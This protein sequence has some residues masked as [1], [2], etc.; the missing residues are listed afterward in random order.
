MI[1]L[2][3]L[4]CTCV[5]LLRC[6]GA[7][8]LIVGL[9]KY[10]HDASCCIISADSGKVLFSQA[11][12]RYSKLKH[13][14]GAVGQLL[15]AGLRYV[16][17][18]LGDIDTVVSNNH[19]FRV[20][21]FE[22]R[23]PFYKSLKYCP[24][25]YGEEH[26][27]VPGATHLELSH[28][29][30]HAWSVTSSLPFSKGIIVVMDGMGESYKAMIEDLSGAEEA[31]GDYMHD[32]KLLKSLG[33][34]S[35]AAFSGVPVN[36]LP[37]SGYR[38][39]ESAYIYDSSAAGLVPLFKRW[40]RERS[41]PELYNHGFENMESLG[42]VYS[43]VSSHLLGD[44]NACGKVM[45]LAS[46]S[47]VKKA[48]AK[49]WMF[50]NAAGEIGLGDNFYHST[51]FMTGNPFDKGGF[52]INWKALDGLE[53]SNSW[54]N[55]NFGEYACIANSVQSDLEGSALSLL[56]SLQT[57]AGEKNVA[58][59]GGV[60]LNSVLNGR[61]K[62][63]LGG[64]VY[65]PPGPG[66]EGVAV[67]CAL[68]GLHRY[69]QRLA[70][71]GIAAGLAPAVPL[72]TL[73]AAAGSFSAYQ[74][75]EYADEDLREALDEWQPFISVKKHADSAAT[76][77]SAVAKLTN[78]KVVAWF[79]GRSEFGQR[80][81]GSRSILA[82]PRDAQMRRFINEKVKERE[83][84]RP[85]APSALDEFA[86]D[87]FDGLANGANDSP[88]MSITT[89]V[90][91]SRRAA[92]PAI[93][94]IDGSARLQTVRR[95]DN[96]LYHEL[97]SAFYRATGVP[98][99]LNT[100]FNRKKQPI[101]ESPTDAVQTLLQ[102]GGSI[103]SLFLGNYEVRARAFPLSATS[104]EPTEADCDVLV[105]ARDVYMTEI[106][107]S[108][109]DPDT[110]VRVRVQDGSEPGEGS[111]WRELP[112]QLTLEMLLLLQSSGGLGDDEDGSAP[113]NVYIKNIYEA[114][115]QIYNNDDA[116]DG[117]PGPQ[118]TWATMRKSL[119]VLHRANLV[120]FESLD[121]DREIEDIDELQRLFK[122]TKI[123]D[124]RGLENDLEG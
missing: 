11:K 26:N 19:H 35:Q 42:A 15:Q 105:F 55:K 87:W 57:A 104:E 5:C 9:N 34:E 61:V 30:A 3:L 59:T 32:L 122:G 8:K 68:Y 111:G 20:R 97:I 94:H 78:G 51:S 85:L 92:V 107:S 22:G 70:A 33:P 109:Q 62:A 73:S 17:A 112:D 50:E 28:H 81:L 60:A 69:K 36:L 100:S 80:A 16:G 119:Q 110:P 56:R 75:E 123:V 44:W 89:A 12:E 88:F 96:P 58:L 63:E 72:S 67:G 54:K 7:S 48:E 106:V 114:I 83:W 25:D 82:D 98:M 77:A 90:K 120:Y 13:D 93:C 45:G 86:G 37:G 41:P 39:A 65:V 101:V 64:G 18:S 108:T 121:E 21:P 24:E 116:S 99:V 40:S 38:E 46:W 74:G 71:D 52:S 47:G 27:L 23:V 1:L 79:Q 53:G 102:S 43:R 117:G 29:L 31:S 95:Q 4:L 6:G 118:V 49:D 10:S 115:S 113:R 124:F 91:E 103:D 14:G 66:D 76:V 84:F 2:L